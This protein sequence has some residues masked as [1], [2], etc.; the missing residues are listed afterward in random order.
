MLIR[1]FYPADTKSAKRQ[2]SHICL[3]ELLGPVHIKA[4]RKMLVK[5]APE[6]V[7]VPQKYI[8]P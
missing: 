7:G 5:L 8:A 2:S 4:A 3:F 6:G 1:S